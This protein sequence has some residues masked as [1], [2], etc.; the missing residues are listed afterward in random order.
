MRSNLVLF[1]I[2]Q[3]ATTTAF[4][5]HC[6][7]SF[8]SNH[9]FELQA[10]Q[11]FKINTNVSGDVSSDG[12]LADKKKEQLKNAASRSAVESNLGVSN[13]RKMPSNSGSIGG[14]KKLSKKAQ[15]LA[16]QRKGDVDSTLQAGISLVGD[17][18]VQIVEAKR[19][20]KRVTLLQGLTSTMEDR[21][22]LLKE[23]K[24]KLGGGGA[25]IEGVVSLIS[26]SCFSFRYIHHYPIADV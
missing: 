24:S 17:Q 22:K 3:C 20:A 2:V 7:A 19:G 9:N 18:D 8:R 6:Q 10:K 15:N 16:E 4:I 12:L 13:K 14:G 25:M 11:K 23:L 26:C 1:L 21:K 5:G